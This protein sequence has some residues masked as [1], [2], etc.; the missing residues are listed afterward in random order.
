VLIIIKKKTIITFILTTPA[1]VVIKT[2]NTATHRHTGEYMAQVM[3]E[4]IEENGA[5]KFLGIVTDNA[6]NMTK[7]WEIL[8]MKFKEYPIAYYGCIAHILNLIVNDVLKLKTY[9]DLQAQCKDIIKNI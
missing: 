6:K 8:Q 9:S 4:V 7:A 2:N 3:A 5:E 1:P